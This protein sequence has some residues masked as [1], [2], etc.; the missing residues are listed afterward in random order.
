MFLP[1]V[2]GFFSAKRWGRVSLP[3]YYPCL[4]ANNKAGDSLNF[5]K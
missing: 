3:H 2:V 5:P 4:V 1:V